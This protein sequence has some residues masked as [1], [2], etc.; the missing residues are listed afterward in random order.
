MSGPF[1]AVLVLLLLSP[2]AGLRRLAQLTAST[3]HGATLLHRRTELS[4]DGGD[5]GVERLLEQLAS[6]SEMQASIQSLETRQNADAL[7]KGSWWAARAA[8]VSGLK[9]PEP[10]FTRLFTHSTWAY[11]TGR[12]ALQRWLST[13]RTWR[14]STVLSNVLPVAVLAATLA[15]LLVS[16]TPPVLRIRI[17]PLPLSLQ[18]TAI[19]LL[20]V[21]RTNNSYQRLSEARE[22]W[23]LAIT[24]C[25]EIAQVSGG[26]GCGRW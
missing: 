19:G 2:S 18:G 15:T 12:P 3:R 26:N 23:S 14:Y 1:S 10:S 16:L 5:K 22:Q 24:L 7:P 11:Y 8:R 13:A 25:R 20:L 4:L 21:F 17:N 9:T 6:V